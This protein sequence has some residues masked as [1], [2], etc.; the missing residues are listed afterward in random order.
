MNPSSP[1]TP[2][3]NGGEPAKP[4]GIEELCEAFL[5]VCE[6]A[7][8]PLEIAGA[9]EFD[10]WN[11]QALRKRYGVSDV[12][13]LA[14]EMYRRVPRRPAEPPAQPDTWKLSTWRPALH[15]VL[16]GI[17]AICF[18]AVAGLLADRNARAV[19]IVALLV[20]WAVSQ[21]LAY[22]G[23]LRLG[24]G[25]PAQAR[26]ILLA[27]LGAGLAAVMAAMYIVSRATTAGLPVLIFGGAMGTYML[28]ATV[29]LVL[30][31]ERQ[32]FL[33]LAPAVLG[34]TA[35]VLAGRP[36]HLEH[37]TWAVLA[38]SPLL[39]LILALASITRRRGDGPKTAGQQ[40]RLVTFAELCAALPSAGFGLVAGGLLVFP[41]AVSAPGHATGALLALLPLTLSMGAAEWMLVWF[42]RRAQQAMRST[43]TLGLFAS[44]ARRI[45]AAAVVQYL[46]VTVLL[47][48]AVVVIATATGMLH[49][50]PAALP[51]IAT[52]LTLGCALFISL[53]LNAFGS[54]IIPVLAGAAALVLEA[55]CRH[56][57]VDGQAGI[58]ITLLI[59]LAAY[60]A[61]ALASA[62]RHAS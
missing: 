3:A 27:G 36:P 58:S 45:L 48:T 59:A 38:A 21:G 33:A 61:V 11:D 1:A 16:Y 10:G 44:R 12:F 6:S 37:A 19:M 15:A 9:L 20:S 46:V 52:Y 14:E 25:V 34:A 13:T 53:L 8:H 23:Y 30:A 42:R 54:R 18:A 35:Y 50:Q 39:A 5:T 55:A 41:V 56:L 7:V 28:G 26:R 57:G 17:P 51:Q 31:G 29:L 32:L 60:A 43:H 47:T 4:R 40:N 24:Q 49:L 22:L 2:G 62:A